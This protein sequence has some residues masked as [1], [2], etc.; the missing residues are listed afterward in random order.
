[1]NAARIAKNDFVNTMGT[2]DAAAIHQFDNAIHKAQLNL[3]HFNEEAKKGKQLLLDDKSAMDEFKESSTEAAQAIG[4]GVSKAFDAMITHSESFGEAMKKATFSMLAAMA[5]KWGA[6]YIAKGMAD[7]WSGNE[8]MAADELAGGLALEVLG[9]VMSGLGS[10]GGAGGNNSTTQSQSSSVDTGGSTRSTIG[11]T[12]VQKLA[13]GGLISAPTLA[14]VG[15]NPGET[16]A[17]LPLS[18]DKA[19]SRIGQSIANSGGGAGDTHFHV[20]VKGLVSPDNLSKV[21]KQINNRVAK[22]Q[23]SLV[24]SNSFRI[25]KR[26]A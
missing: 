1:L 24:A 12:G 26:S 15:E 18:N 8:A 22:G 25:T 4:S 10:S 5:E 13:M 9:G 14:V 3:K 11:V 19:M 7:I 20:N 21:M 2:K 23:G 6:Y 16:E 17:V